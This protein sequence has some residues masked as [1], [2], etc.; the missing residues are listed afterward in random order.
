MWVFSFAYHRG[1]IF[2]CE[3]NG[4]NHQKLQSPTFLLPYPLCTILSFSG[5]PAIMSPS[6]ISYCIT[7]KT[8]ISLHFY[9][10]TCQSSSISHIIYSH[11]DLPLSVQLISPS[12]APILTFHSPLFQDV[13]F[14]LCSMTLCTS[15]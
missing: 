11:L 14:F 9:P 3:V 4:G 10:L 2:Q 12:A 7:A 6:A 1:Y 13:S 8:F 15:P 5:I